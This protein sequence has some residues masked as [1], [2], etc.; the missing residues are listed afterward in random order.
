MWQLV[1]SHCRESLDWIPSI[2]IENVVVYTKCGVKPNH[3][4]PYT[5]RAIQNVGREAETFA[6]HLFEQYNHIAPITVFLQGDPR[7]SGAVLEEVRRLH[8]LREW[9]S[10]CKL[11]GKP[12]LHALSDGCPSHCGLAIKATCERLRTARATCEPPFLFAA[13]GQFILS[14][15]RAHR[16]GRRR[17]SVMKDLLTQ[18]SL[19]RLRAPLYPYVF[20]RLWGALLC[21]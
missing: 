7:H 21:S 12:I 5:Y 9:T 10:P 19:Y 8:G 6:R 2:G 16:M 1:V 20:E 4:L 3:S 15:A 11:L 13:G 18:E 17:Y 14:R